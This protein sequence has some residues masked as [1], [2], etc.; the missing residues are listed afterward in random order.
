MDINLFRRRMYVHYVCVTA[1]GRRKIVLN[2]QKE[3]DTNFG[4]LKV[5]HNLYLAILK[6]IV[7]RKYNISFREPLVS[8]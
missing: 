8:L 6:D 2:R 7:G 1:K 3:M 4:N 5:Q